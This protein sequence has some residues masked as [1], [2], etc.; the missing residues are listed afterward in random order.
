MGKE[1]RLKVFGCDWPTRDGTGVRDYIHVL[2]L[3]EGHNAA[4]NLLRSEEPQ[5]LTM[6]LGTGSGHTV[7]EVARA[8]AQ[9]ADKEIP[10]ELI[11]RRKGDSAMSVAD[12]S[13]AARRM[14][15]Q[16]RRSLID[17]CRDAWRWQQHNPEGYLSEK[18]QAVVTS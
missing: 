10:I 3:A 15:W 16:A 18:G 11:D 4:L 7:L 2:D 13:R 9:A 5:L 17:M 1:S 8:F 6:N 12:P 14:G